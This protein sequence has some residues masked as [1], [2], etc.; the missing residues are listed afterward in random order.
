MALVAGLVAKGFWPNWQPQL[1][2]LCRFFRAEGS[3]IKLFMQSKV[4]QQVR[5][6]LIEVC[7]AA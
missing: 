6:F 1:A 5:N 3:P 2:N 7:L 4:G